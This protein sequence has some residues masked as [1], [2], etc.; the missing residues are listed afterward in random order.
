MGP[1]TA[2]I[3]SRVAP[4]GRNRVGL[5]VV[6]SS[7]VDSSPTRDGP[8]SGSNFAASASVAAVGATIMGGER[9]TPVA[10]HDH[11]R[12]WSGALPAESSRALAAGDEVR[13]AEARFAVAE[14]TIVGGDDL[15]ARRL[16]H[17]LARRGV[18]FV[19]RTE[20][21]VDVG[22]A[23]GDHAE[24]QRRARLDALGDG[25]AVVAKPDVEV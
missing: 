7:T 23:L 2:S 11:E 16:E 1:I 20:A 13:I 18:P 10:H 4:P 14:G 9:A 17:A 5:S 21:R 3:A 25:E 24:L 15:A 6:R 8:P 12:H 22:L 19:R